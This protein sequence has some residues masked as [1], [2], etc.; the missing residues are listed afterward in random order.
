MGPA[1]GA[2][3]RCSA[4]PSRA[5]CSGTYGY[6]VFSPA[7]DPYRELPR[8]C[9]APSGSTR[10]ATSDKESYEYDA[11]R[12]L[13]GGSTRTRHTARRRDPARGLPR[14]EYDRGGGRNLA[15]SRTSSARTVLASSSTPRRAV[16]HLSLRYLS[17]DQAIIIVCDGGGATGPFRARTRA[18]STPWWSAPFDRYRHRR[19]RR[20]PRVTCPPTRPGAA[21]A[22]PHDTAGEGRP[23]VCA[24][25]VCSGSGPQGGGIRPGIPRA[26]AQSALSKPSHCRVRCRRFACGPADNPSRQHGRGRRGHGTRPGRSGALLDEGAVHARTLLRPTLALVRAENGCCSS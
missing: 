23:D 4:G 16:L 8:Y 14:D 24:F 6:W 13:P 3:H 10:P 15:R 11:V 7:S 25:L 1:R 18:F 20:G 17:L 19:I 2:H 5:G 22:P 26:V 9:A 12:R 21:A